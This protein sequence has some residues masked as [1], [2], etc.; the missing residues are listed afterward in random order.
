MVYSREWGGKY[1]PD[2]GCGILCARKTG[3][4][5]WELCYHGRS[6]PYISLCPIG[7]VPEPGA[8]GWLSLLVN[9][10]EGI[11]VD[12]F[13]YKQDKVKT[14]ERIG[15]RIRLNRSKI[16]DASD[17]NTDFDDLAESI[18]SGYYLKMDLRQMRNFIIL[19]S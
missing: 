10:G 18:Q 4:Q 2:S 15:R 11:D 17:T 14:I 13:L 7:K 19:L 9:A 3:L 6:I 8:A 5:A 12:L 1:R 16:K